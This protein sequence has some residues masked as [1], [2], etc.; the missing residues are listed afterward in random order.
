M[1]NTT[2]DSFPKKKK[3]D[4]KWSFLQKPNFPSKILKWRDTVYYDTPKFSNVL[5][6]FSSCND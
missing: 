5:F 4:A 2:Q 3:S 6:G 1:P